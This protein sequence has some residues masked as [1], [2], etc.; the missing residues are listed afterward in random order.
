M[1]RKPSKP[2]A[3][4]VAANKQWLKEKAKE[5][6]VKSLEK[7]L[8]Y[9]EIDKGEEGGKQ[10]TAVD[11]VS[12][13]YEGW[14]TDGSKFDS[15]LLGAPMACRLRDLIEGWVIGL[16]HMHVGDRWELYVPAELGYGNISQPGIPAG[17]TLIFRVTLVGVV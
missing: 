6:G 4:Y 15:C 5:E 2:N 16:Q 3:A 10:P 13:Y 14:L 8:L 12:V 1:A 11:V 9:K 17:S 7:G